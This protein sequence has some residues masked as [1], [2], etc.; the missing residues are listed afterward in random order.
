MAWTEPRSASPG[1][2]P[3]LHPVSR[4]QE[5]ESD[6]AL[7]VGGCG[8]KV[9]GRVAQSDVLEGSSPKEPGG[10]LQKK[11]GIGKGSPA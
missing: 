8:R 2:A 1:A 4:A 11:G 10:L 5:G 7:G 3:H 6:W 9:E